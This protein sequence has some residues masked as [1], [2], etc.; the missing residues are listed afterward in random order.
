M[1][2]PRQ[3]PRPDDGS[4][5]S[6][7]SDEAGGGGSI[8][9]AELLAALTT[10]LDMTEGQPAGHCVR[11]CH[12]GLAV[13]SRLGLDEDAMSDLCHTI[14]MKDLGCS[15]NAARICGLYLTDDHAF[16]RAFK[17]VDGSLPQLLRFGLV[18]AGV[19]AGMIARFR[20]VFRGLRNREEA[21]RAL[22]RVRCERG[23][24]IAT[25]LGFGGRVAQAIR[26]LD[27]RWDGKGRPDGI[28]GRTIPTLSQI[29]LLAQVCDVFHSDG[30]PDIA[31]RAVVSR[32][33]TWF[34]P[35]VVAAFDAICE[36]PC[37][38]QVL[39]SDTLEE[40]ILMRAPA[41][42]FRRV[43]D[44]YLDDVAGAFARIIDAKSS[45][46]AGH[47]D[48]VA[49]IADAIAAELGYSAGK[50]RWLRRGA[51]LH[52]IGKLGISSAILDK[53]ARLTEREFAAIR[54][55]PTLSVDILSRV[56]VFADLLRIVGDHH[57]KLDGRGYPK[58]LTG[59]EISLDTRIVTVADIFEALTA[60]RPYREPMTVDAS[61]ALMD[62]LARAEIDP[63]CF[64]ALKSA[65]ER[66]PSLAVPIHRT[67][68]E[69]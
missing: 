40:E 4:P 14:L 16:K 36:D 2:L 28:A 48:R 11:S 30:G 50:R 31:R 8:R 65:L 13:G 26:H 22:T 37:F 1:T 7:E 57:E 47:S 17:K 67:Q 54:R 21:A 34:D 25:K 32:S 39:A 12:I 3:P 44:A 35:A 24:E 68:V 52:D 59:G 60:A 58:G 27:E 63:V 43:D 45:Y 56:A 49:L 23:A 9:V 29:A 61:V 15:S 62:D 5:T 20:I 41:T 38:W 19:H 66:T 10:A 42:A 18:H 46:T 33:G 69:A 53:T 64:A 55:H 6:K 51:L